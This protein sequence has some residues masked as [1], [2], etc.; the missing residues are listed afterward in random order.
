MKV[1]ELKAG[2]IFC[3]EGTRSYPK[4]KLMEGYVDLRDEFVNRLPGD[5]EVEVISLEELY[6]DFNIRFKI[7]S[8]QVDALLTKLIRRFGNYEDIKNV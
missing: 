4:I 5:W 7:S 6:N 8:K 1:T 2:T 3:I